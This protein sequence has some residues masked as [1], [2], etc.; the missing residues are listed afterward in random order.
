MFFWL[1]P[2]NLVVSS[3]INFVSLDHPNSKVPLLF[4]GYLLF[5]CFVGGLFVF[6][7]LG[8]REKES[9][10]MF[11]SVVNRYVFCFIN[12]R[13]VGLISVKFL[14]TKLAFP[15]QRWLSFHVCSLC[16]WWEWPTFWADY[17]FKIFNISLCSCLYLS[18]LEL[19][20]SVYHSYFSI[21]L[22]YSC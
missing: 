21:Q 22:L 1:S 11:S 14:R 20:N 12:A 5:Y 17:N 6:C 8:Q 19:N 3:I 18:S 13:F 10:N 9:K 4:A 15:F 16:P 2:T 7:I